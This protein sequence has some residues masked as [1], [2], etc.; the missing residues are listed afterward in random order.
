MSIILRQHLSLPLEPVLGLPANSIFCSCVD[1][2]DTNERKRVD[3][4]HLFNCR[5][6]FA[7]EW[8]H[9][10]LQ[11]VLQTAVEST[12]LTPE[13]ERIC[14]QR[15]G[16]AP[17]GRRLEARRFDITLH[18]LAEHCKLVHCDVTVASHTAVNNW[19]AANTR[20]LAN[21]DD[22]V[23]K[24]HTKYRADYD[25][26]TEVFLPVAFE[27]TGA[28]HGNV[29]KV[30]SLLAARVNNQGPPQS[31]WAASTFTSYWT[32]RLS[33]ALWQETAMASL[34][35]SKAALR[36]GRFAGATQPSSA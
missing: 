21:A 27:T 29:H 1:I 33:V 7:F 20:P 9:K 30:L 31:N 11:R 2:T 12:D 25:P 23:K 17:S 16:T 6:E 10:A 28:M 14:V 26:A 22:A 15:H 4:I 19:A 36:R 5:N 34:R 8:R 35:L 32:T 24:K 18:G 3:N 13:M